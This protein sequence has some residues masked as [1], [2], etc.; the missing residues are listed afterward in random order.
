MKEE[1]FHDKCFDLDIIIYGMKEVFCLC[2]VICLILINV[3]K[4]ENG[5]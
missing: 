1:Y 5:I 2:L 4:V 3:V